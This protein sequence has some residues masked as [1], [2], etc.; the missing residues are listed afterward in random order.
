MHEKENPFQLDVV[1]IRLVPDAPLYSKE[2]IDHPQKVV[3]LLGKHIAD[4][5]REV[6]YVININ[7][8][9][10]PINCSLVSIGTLNSCMLH[11]REVFKSAILSNASGIILLHNHPSNNVKPSEDDIAITWQMK[12]ACDCI[13]IWLEDH[14]IVGTDGQ[15]YY[16]FCEEGKLLPSEHVLDMTMNE[17]KKVR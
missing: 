3:E 11:P 16:S 7:T 15:K 5:D 14:I 13:G 10:V 9:G 1:S 6:I 2:P 4:M 12:K 17:P 8:K